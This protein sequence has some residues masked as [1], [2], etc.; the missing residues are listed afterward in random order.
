MVP[1]SFVSHCWSDALTTQT[2][3]WASAVTGLPVPFYSWLPNFF[4]IL[5]RRL[6]AARFPGGLSALSHPSLEGV[7]TAYSSWYGICS[8]VGE[9]IQHYKLGC[10]MIFR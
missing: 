2:V 5:S 9:I 10:Q 8:I 6:S 7:L 1:P 4:G 3:V